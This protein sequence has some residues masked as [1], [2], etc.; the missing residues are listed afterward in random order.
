MPRILLTSVFKPFGVDN[1][2]SRR[3]S[4]IE[5]FHNQITKY[6]G[7]FSIRTHFNT[8][9]L[10]A[11]ANNLDDTPVTVLDYPTRRRFQQELARGY[12]LVGIGSI[13]PNFQKVK[14]MAE[15]VRRISPSSQII[16]GGFC[17][18][19]EDVK[20]LIPL[21]HVCV[22]EGISFMRELLG[23]PAEF[24]FRQPDTFSET[25]E[26]LGV[27]ILRGGYHP[28]LVVGVGCSYGCDF[29]SP[30]HF[31]GRKHLQFL[32][33]GRQIYTEVE[34]LAERFHADTFT[35]IGDDNYLIDRKRN[36]ELHDLVVQGGRQ[37]NF[38]IFASANLVSE[39]DPGELAEMGVAVIWIGRE[40]KFAG[41][42]KNRQ[43]DMVG[44]VDNLRRHGIKTILS[45]ILLME[46]HNRENIQE[47]IAEHL[48]C[49]PAF[50]QFS[51]YAPCPGT[52]LWD[53]YKKENRLLLDIPY[54]DM[55]AFKQPWFVHPN[56]TLIEAEKIQEA[57][58][59]RD[60]H[61]LGPGLV[62]FI[63][64][65]FEGY[66]N[67][68]RSPNPRLQARARFFARNMGLYRAL[69][70][71]SE[72]LVPKPDMR[73]PI[74]ELRRQ[75]EL[76]FGSASLLEHLEGWGLSQFGRVRELRTRL[77]GDD[78]Q[79]RTRLTVYPAPRS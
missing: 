33:T 76:E 34:R 13:I 52:P 57:A 10:H 41:Y 2:Y 1:A 78:L 42:S 74:R 60:Y 56:F 59:L 21:D 23:L 20:K 6:Q 24:E 51:H 62:R 70:L 30:S 48:K 36:Q 50:S 66:Q 12:D 4:K 68:K 15:D 37:W 9:G 8:F 31:F 40:S 43:V 28:F 58:Y 47:D 73:E 32:K 77:F 11:I 61:E 5:L 71:G 39:W 27:P 17:A 14:A 18:G 45:T 22:G 35:F 16:L 65:D 75:I 72:R 38:F 64:D 79:P 7:P 54:E 25:Q 63:R 69:L 3:D 19:V 46:F 26:V 53:K 49:R 29:C 67:L 44:L 55:H